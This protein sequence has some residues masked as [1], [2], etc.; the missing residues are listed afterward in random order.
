MNKLRYKCGYES[1][2]DNYYIECGADYSLSY[3]ILYNVYGAMMNRSTLV[4]G[5]FVIV[6]TIINSIDHKRLWACRA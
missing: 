6:S 1:Y 4:S 2:I 5:K 3:S